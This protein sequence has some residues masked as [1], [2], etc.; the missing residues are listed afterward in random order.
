MNMTSNTGFKGLNTEAEFQ[1]SVKYA[2]FMRNFIITDSGSIKKRASVLRA[3]I[4]P[5]DIK[6]IWCGKI[7]DRESVFIAAGNYLYEHGHNSIATA[8]TLIGYIGT[9]DCSMFSFGNYLYI[10]TSSH[11]SKYDGTAIY[12]VE[13]YIPCVAISCIPSTGEGELFEQINLL[14]EKRRQIFSG[15]GTTKKYKLA[16][17]GVNTVYSVKINGV[18]CSSITLNTADSTL[19][20]EDAP[21]SGLNNVEVTYGVTR[22]QSDRERITK[23]TRIMLFG[24]NSNGRAFLWGN[25]DYPNYRFNSELADGVPSVEYFP[26]NSF[27]IIGNSKINCI[28]Q[29]YDKQLIFTENEAFYSY[30]ELRDD[31][32]NNIYSSFPVYNLNGSKGC[33]I[34]TDGCIINNHPVTLSHDGINIWESTAVENERNATLISAPINSLMRD[35]I[36]LGD[37]Y[38]LD[39][40]ATR[41]LFVIHEGL[42]YVYNYGNGGWYVHDGFDGSCYCVYEGTLYFARGD[43]LYF[44]NEKLDYDLGDA[45][46]AVWES[47]A[48]TNGHGSGFC[49]IAAIGSDLHIQSP[50]SLKFTVLKPN[51]EERSRE[52]DFSLSEDEFMRLSFRPALKRVMPFKVKITAS[53]IGNCTVHGI[54]IKTKEKERSRR[55]GIL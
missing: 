19:N 36:A 40:Q 10:K 5:A 35:V 22:S 24:G 8:P 54:T 28:V 50:I 33:I 41:E 23:C 34:E 12:A 6:A 52:F 44:Y 1:S 30:C 42:A 4:S 45:V 14:T 11:Y 31:G 38:L 48:V 26:V 47:V 46:D 2:S 39:M 13:G 20:F 43:V 53:G 49:D 9:G 55:N 16:E 15:D 37:V 51:G 25:P 21:A 17:N 18:S 7:A 29:Q 3:C 32:L 27:T